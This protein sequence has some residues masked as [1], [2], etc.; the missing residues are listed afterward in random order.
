[1]RD[2]IKLP[3][4][5]D[6]HVFHVVVESPRCSAI[7]LKY[8]PDLGAMSLSRPL[9]LGITH[10]HDSEFIPSTRAKDGDP[11]D[12]IVLWD[13]SSFPGVA[14]PCRALGVLQIEQKGEKNKRI[15]N[16]RILAIPEPP[17]RF[18]V[19]NV[20]ALSRRL[21]DELDH[22]FIAATALEGKDPK[23]IG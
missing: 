6:K 3:T 8:D 9:V 16:D 23:I 22:F 13:V 15:R 12:A 2:L 18:G 20:H 10:P 1:M 11:V 7:K 19:K 17:R 14:I 5:V 4:F 21:R